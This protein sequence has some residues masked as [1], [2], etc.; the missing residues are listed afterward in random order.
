MCKFDKLLLLVDAGIC[1]MIQA[2]VDAIENKHNCAFEL[3]ASTMAFLHETDLPVSL[4]Q[5]GIERTAENLDRIVNH[6]YDENKLIHHEPFVVTKDSM[7]AAII[8]ADN[9][10][11]AFLARQK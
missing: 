6:A 1:N 11:Q 4:A 7:K 5:I 2:L 8:A 9:M 3:I 10:G